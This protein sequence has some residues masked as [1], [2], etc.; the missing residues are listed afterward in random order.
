MSGSSSKDKNLEVPFHRITLS[1]G[2]LEDILFLRQLS[3]K[4]NIIKKNQLNKNEKFH[5]KAQQCFA[6]LHIKSIFKFFAVQWSWFL[7][8]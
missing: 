6:F 1:F 4:Q 3:T 2:Y 8:M 5:D 7:E